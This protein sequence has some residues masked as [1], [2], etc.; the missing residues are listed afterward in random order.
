MDDLSQ[1]KFDLNIYLTYWK[2][3]SWRSLILFYS[4]SSSAC[5][6][7]YFCL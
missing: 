3:L 7:P 2:K 5:G 6:S 4:I 1:L